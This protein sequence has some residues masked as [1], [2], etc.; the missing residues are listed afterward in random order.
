M[1]SQGRYTGLSSGSDD[2]RIFFRQ[3]PHRASSKKSYMSQM[4]AAA[5]SGRKMARTNSIFSGNLLTFT[6]ALSWQVEQIWSSMTLDILFPLRPGGSLHHQ[7]HS[8]HVLSAYLGPNGN[9]E[10][11]SVVV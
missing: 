5:S 6:W 3:D 7:K 8:G 9:S 2:A 10:A 4:M 1:T 11:I